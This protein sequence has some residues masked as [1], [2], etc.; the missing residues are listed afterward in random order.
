MIINNF[1]CL[2]PFWNKN[3]ID[4]HAYFIT[5]ININICFY[6]LSNEFYSFNMHFKK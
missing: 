1:K 2:V 3:K 4:H 6:L 5:I